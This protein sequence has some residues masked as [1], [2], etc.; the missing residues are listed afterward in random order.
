MYKIYFKSA[1]RNLINKAWFTVVNIVG[2]AI[3]IACCLLL[4]KY[5][6]YEKNYDSYAKG[7][8]YY[9]LR[10]DNYEQGRLQWQAATCYPI[11]GPYLKRDF[12]EVESFCRLKNA[13]M[14]F[15]NDAK[16]VKFFE[17]RGFFADTSVFN[18]LNVQLVDGAASNTLLGPDKMVMSE[19]MAF[20]YFGQADA[21][22]KILTIR[23]AQTTQ[24]YQVTGVFKN[25]ATN[26]HLV[27]DY[28]VSYATLGKIK[29]LQ[30][31]TTNPTETQ[32][33]WYDFYT[34]IKLKPGTDDRQLEAKLPAFCTRYYPDL[35]WARANKA[36]D[37][38]RLLP[39]ADIH[40]KSNYF[41]EAEIN[42]SASNVNLLFVIAIFILATAWINYINLATARSVERA[43]EVGIRKVLGAT[44]GS[45]VK[46]FLAE[47]LLLNAAALVLALATVL[48]VTPI[49]NRFIGQTAAPALFSI[50]AGYWLL[51][52]CIFVAGTVLSGLYP[53]FVLSG[54]HPIKVL[55]GAFKNVGGGL[56]LRKSLIVMQ[57]ATSIILIAGTFVVYK[58]VRF[59]RSQAL[60]FNTSQTLVVNGAGAINDSLYGS[61]YHAF[62]TEVLRLPGVQSITASSNVMGQEISWTMDLKRMG[63]IGKTYTVYNLGI[64]YDFINAYGMKIVAG[65]G[66]SKSYGT[67]KT[68]AIL[69]ESAVKLLGY[70]SP[71]AAINTKIVEGLTDTLTVV[72]VVA[73]FHHLGLQKAIDPQLLLPMDETREYYLI[74]SEQNY[75]SLKLS[76][77]NMQQTIGSIRALWDHYFPNDPFNFFFLDEYY[78]KQYEASGL[79]GRVFGLFALLAILIACFGLSG[80]SAYNVLRRT[81]EIGIRKVVGASVNSLLYLLCKDF[82]LLVF[83]AFVIAVPLAWWG[84]GTW[85]QGFA[86][87]IGMGMGVFLAA[88]T[89]AGIIALATI[90]SQAIKA[91]LA[92]PVVS[93][94]NE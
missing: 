70:K 42:G 46:Q 55:K 49:F 86:Y 24:H 57:F 37:E 20:K 38:L 59:M 4:F 14:L 50:E 8:P 73:D 93:L 71:T 89:L 22:G 76:P 94:R 47:S 77:G 74:P 3:G 52:F 26:S 62:K 1:Y 64:D 16:Q 54:Y 21:V 67:D 87:R 15:S 19:S 12:P 88:G 45:L 78:N 10:L 69:N 29:R 82:L 11:T 17:T 48:A 84:M 56:A 85:L 39:V 66:F 7:K 79:F 6:S 2:L 51:F 90:A 81:K 25:Y 43:R 72:G 75:Y 60:G 13:A 92:N 68:A 32:W 33:G 83:L 28:L 44:R 65:R 40:L 18:M 53:A 5:V 80:L 31:D 58:Q 30:G 41:Q 35:N 91:A 61:I 63:S 34:Y 36:H 23:D 9:R 27:I